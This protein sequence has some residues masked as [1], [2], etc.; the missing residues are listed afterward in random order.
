MSA[1]PANSTISVYMNLRSYRRDLRHESLAAICKR[2]RPLVMSIP[3]EE[4]LVGVLSRDTNVKDMSSYMGEARFNAGRG[5]PIVIGTLGQV[6]FAEAQTNLAD[7]NFAFQIGSDKFLSNTAAG[8]SGD[9]F[10]D[11]QALSPDI[12]NC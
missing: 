1:Q 4:I 5:F 2:L 9:L 8:L 6:S 7:I 10:G 11:A 12:T 3:G